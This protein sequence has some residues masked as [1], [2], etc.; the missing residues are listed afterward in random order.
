MVPEVALLSPLFAVLAYAAAPPTV[1]PTLAKFDGLAL[2]RMVEHVQKAKDEI[3]LVKN[4][5]DSQPDP[6][7]DLPSKMFPSWGCLSDRV[8]FK[9]DEVTIAISAH[10]DASDNGPVT[11]DIAESVATVD[12]S[13]A[14]WSMED[15]TTFGIDS[16]VNIGF[17]GIGVSG[18]VHYSNTNSNG[19]SGE[20]SKQKEYRKEV[21][22][23]RECP[24]NTHCSVQTWTYMA[25]LKGNCPLIPMVDPVCWKPRVGKDWFPATFPA[26]DLLRD[27]KLLRGNLSLPAVRG[28]DTTWDTIGDLYFT[29]TNKDGSPTGA[30]LPKEFA[31]NVWWADEEKYSINYK[32]TTPCT[33]SAP[34][35]DS[36]GNP[37]R[38]QVNLKVEHGKFVRDEVLE[39]TGYNFTVIDV[40]ESAFD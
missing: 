19:Q 17:A 35:T 40:L 23:T 29:M 5:I 18:G 20:N 37:R 26:Y 9:V 10:E 12:T 7:I 15:S 1:I 11:M 38:T 28:H 4:F 30:V 8:Q 25:T 22:R 36:Q 2:G 6:Y 16:S 33:I 39:P 14:G 21:G 34:I 3:A 27:N 24:K 31:E 13:T 32:F